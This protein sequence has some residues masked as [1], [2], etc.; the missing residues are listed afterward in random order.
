MSIKIYSMSEIS[1]SFFI[2]GY[3]FKLSCNEFLIN[4]IIYKCAIKYNCI[5][6]F[7]LYQ[8]FYWI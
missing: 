4:F 1:A 2:F 5:A 8:I 6:F 7:A 3:N